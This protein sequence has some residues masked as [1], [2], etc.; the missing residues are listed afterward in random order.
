M[1]RANTPV[2]NQLDRPSESSH[3]PTVAPVRPLIRDCAERVEVAEQ[4]V[5]LLAPDSFAADQYRALRHTVEGLRK[6][7]GLH[8]IAVTSPGP[9]DGKTITTLNL[10]GALA[11]G[12]DARVLVVD[13]DLR[14]PSV[15]KYLGLGS[16]RSPGLVDALLDPEYEM[17]R[18]VRRLE[19][20]NLSVLLAGQPQAAPYELLNS[21]RLENLLREARELYDYVLV[22]TPP[23][24]PM[25]DS[26][27]IGRW[28]DSFLV[29]V[30]AHKTPRK[31]LSHA[32]TLLNPAKVIGLVFNGDD[33]HRAHHYGYYDYYSERTNDRAAARWWQT[34]LPRRGPGSSRW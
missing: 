28:V 10:A 25:P 13:A 4:L 34:L 8:V 26:R 24:V 31:L 14:R 1:T 3:R 27:L 6:E 12:Q 20:F 2:I 33:Q 17:A 5:S 21:M 19:Q 29:V 16:R 15:A 32:L 11:Q 23:L 22:D 18:A 9:G 7:S 30:G